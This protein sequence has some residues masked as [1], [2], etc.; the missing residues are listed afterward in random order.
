[1][2]KVTSELIQSDWS[3]LGHVWWQLRTDEANVVVMDVGVDAGD[4]SWR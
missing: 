4:R 3:Y 1:M 2:K